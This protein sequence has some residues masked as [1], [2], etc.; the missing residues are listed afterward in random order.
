MNK[1]TFRGSLKIG[2]FLLVTLLGAA[3]GCA[4]KPIVRCQFDSQTDF[5][6]FKTYSTEA[7]KS[8][9]LDERI[10]DS[11][12]L[13]QVIQES[14]EQQL[15]AKGLKKAAP[16]EASTHLNV[17]WAGAIRFDDATA[18]SGAPG[19]DIGASD[20]D[21]GVILDSGSEGGAVPASITKGGI[22]VDLINA[23]TKQ[24]VWRGGIGAILKDKIPDPERVERLNQ[25]MAELFTNYPPKATAR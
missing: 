14:I 21:A 16:T 17:R 2:A 9:S 3:V 6:G 10:L 24:V 12:P 7:A 11:K 15:Q 20:P 23:K 8:P 4:S 13:S 5:S 1:P 19:V 22:R 18:S 25:L